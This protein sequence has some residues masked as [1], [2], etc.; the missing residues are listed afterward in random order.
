M[1]QQHSETLRYRGREYSLRVLPL[2]ACDRPDV[3]QRM[4][5]FKGLSTG[6]WRGYAGAWAIRDGRLWLEELQATVQPLAGYDSQDSERD[7]S[8]LFCDDPAPVLADWFGGDLVTGCGKAERSSMHSYEHPRLR[9][10]HVARGV[11]QRVEV[12][13]NR[14]A[15]RTGRKRYAVWLAVLEVI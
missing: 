13:D 1:T 7:L 6:L 8:W 2:E 14:V 12:R 15:L 3:M 11:V 10:F 9:V 4:A 5:T